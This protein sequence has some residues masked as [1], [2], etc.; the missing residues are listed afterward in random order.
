MSLSCDS[1]SEALWLSR[2]LLNSAQACLEFVQQHA[3][4]GDVASVIAAIDQFAANHMM[5]IVGLHKGA[6]V[7]AE[8]HKK[9]PL[10]MVEAGGYIGYSAIRFAALQRQLAG[11]QS[12]HYYSFE[13]ST[14]FATTMRQVGWL[15]GKSLF[16]IVSALGFGL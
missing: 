11:N 7:E 10:V 15:L 16:I 3:Q 12:S 5:M 8:I 13:I 1:L 9:R 2:S 6:V 14:E 4:Q